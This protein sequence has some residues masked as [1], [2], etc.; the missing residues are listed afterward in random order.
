M[1]KKIF[2]TLAF[3]ALFASASFGQLKF[4]GGLSYGTEAENIGIN[5]RG[6]YSI[7]DKIAIVPGFTYFLPKDDVTFW[8]FN[9]DCHYSFNEMFY[10]L[11][12]LNYTH[13]KYEMPSGSLFGVAFE[14]EDI[15]DSA[16]GL[17]VGAG[18]K[19]GSKF[20]GEAKYVLSDYDQLVL[21]VGILFG[22]N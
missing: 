9:A 4:G 21:T 2:L 10:G 17:N 12:G 7:N 18:A 8:E 20:F 16:I 13:F 1:K 11:G 6:D 14:G 15:T 22:G 5:I 3:V 19:L